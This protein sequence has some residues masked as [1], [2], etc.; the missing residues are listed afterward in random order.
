[1]SKSYQK[2]FRQLQDELN[3]LADKYN[4]AAN[5][6]ELMKLVCERRPLKTSQVHNN[7]RTGC[8]EFTVLGVGEFYHFG[9]RWRAHVAIHENDFD[10]AQ[11]LTYRLMLSGLTPLE[12]VTQYVHDDPDATFSDDLTITIEGLYERLH[13]I[14]DATTNSFHAG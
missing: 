9:G 10:I 13:I 11:M 3:A 5:P 12:F 8:F 1:M 7:P 4:L 2:N 6:Q 14:F